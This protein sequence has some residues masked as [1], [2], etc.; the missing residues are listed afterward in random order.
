MDIDAARGDLTRALDAAA[1]GDRSGSRFAA[2]RQVLVNRG[3]EALGL[4]PVGGRTLDEILALAVEA[5]LTVA[6]KN[7]AVLLVLANGVDGLNPGR[8]DAERQ[9][10]S[11]LERALLNPLRRAGYPF[12]GSMYDKRQA[13]ARLHLTIDEHLRP[14]EP[15]IPAWIHGLRQ[16]DQD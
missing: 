16:A 10:R 9:L 15:S 13:L 7:F 1:S 5:P 4:T 14:L 6:L 2:A 8:G 12:N 3:A 11:L